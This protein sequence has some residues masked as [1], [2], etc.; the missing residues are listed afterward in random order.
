[1]NQYIISSKN[2]ALLFKVS[3]ALTAAEKQ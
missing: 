2:I 3:K 1:M